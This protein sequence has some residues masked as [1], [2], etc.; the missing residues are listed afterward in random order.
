MAGHHKGYA[1][2]ATIYNRVRRV[3]SEQNSRTFKDISSVPIEKETVIFHQHGNALVFVDTKT[4]RITGGNRRIINYGNLTQINILGQYIEKHPM[5]LM[6]SRGFKDI[7]TKTAF[8]KEFPGLE[9]KFQNSRGFKEIKDAYEPC[10]T[11]AGESINM[12]VDISQREQN[13]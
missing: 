13:K 8:F 1:S 9:N 10:N 11:K 4:A 5:L 12:F 7:V 6:F 2:G 3:L